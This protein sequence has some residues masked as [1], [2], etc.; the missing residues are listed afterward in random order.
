M[1]IHVNISKE[2]KHKHLYYAACAPQWPVRQ[3]PTGCTQCSPRRGRT[4]K[5]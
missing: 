4:S 2:I 5:A 1:H 3:L